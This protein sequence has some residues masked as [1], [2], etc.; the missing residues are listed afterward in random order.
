MPMLKSTLSILVILVTAL[1]P[2]LAM[3]G[4]E[5]G[6]VEPSPPEG[7]LNP[8][9][10]IQLILGLFVVL[11][12]I[13]ASGWLFKRFGRWQGGYSDQ[14]KIVGGLAVGARERIVLV[15][16]G[17]QQLL[18]GIAPGNIR[19]LHVLDEP[20]P[21]VGAGGKTEPLAEKFA[22]IFKKQRNG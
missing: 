19:T 17:E 21:E 5:A 12:L 10:A 18:V 13:V 3:A 22:T 16:V 2:L 8:G 14:L 7:V 15:Q 6:A 4:G 11:F 20:L 9:S 1:F